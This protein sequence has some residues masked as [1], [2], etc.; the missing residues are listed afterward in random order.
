[1]KKILIFFMTVTSLFLLSS[2]SSEQHDVYVTV[3]PLKFLTEELFEGTDYTVGIV[4]GVSS[5][6]HSAEWAPKQIIAMQEAELLFYIGANYDQYITKKL[7]VFK[8]S[9]VQLIKIE[10]E[11]DYIEYIPGVVDDHDHD[12]DEH[13]EPTILSEDNITLG[14]DPHFWISPKRMLD[15]L[16]L[17][18][19]KY[20]AAFPSASEIIDENYTVIKSRLEELH[21]DFSEVISQMTK[22]ALTST[23]LYGYLRVDYGLVYISISPGYHEEPDNMISENTGIILEEITY[24]SINKIIYEK[25]RT[26]PASD[27]IYAEMVKMNIEPEKLEFDVLQLLSDTDISQN[28]DYITE[29]RENLSII[30]KAGQ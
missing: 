7:S 10:D 9:N 23:N 4:P 29:M 1:M 16:D 12:A 28:K 19:D 15:V 11:T 26:S 13:D 17:L 2:C 5:H 22:P 18:Y 8:D 27:L 14:L 21:I 30:Q 25:K 24:H 6:E 3:Y 20:I